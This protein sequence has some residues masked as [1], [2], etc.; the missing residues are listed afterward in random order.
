ME[1]ASAKGHQ[2]MNARN[3]S[4]KSSVPNIDN[5]GKFRHCLGIETLYLLIYPLP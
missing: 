2:G 3:K 5:K 4:G 1:F